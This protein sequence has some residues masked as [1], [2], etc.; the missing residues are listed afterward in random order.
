MYRLT[1]VI[2]LAVL[3]LGIS[4]DPGW[5]GQDYCVTCAGPDKIYLCTVDTGGAASAGLSQQLYC[6]RE[7]ARQGGHDSCSVKRKAQAGC[8]GEPHTLVYGGDNGSIGGPVIVTTP[9]IVTT[10]DARPEPDVRQTD[11]EAT[12]NPSAQP[13]DSSGQPGA[14]D[15]AAISTP[16]IAKPPPAAKGPPK[17]VVELAKRAAA[18]SKKQ[19]SNAG[20]AVKG[21]VKSAGKTVGKAA[22]KTW[23]CLTSF[24]TKC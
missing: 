11:A 2:M 15:P 8:N 18:S 5:T 9:K 13:A 4:K 6:I 24:F 3:L 1:A 21:G 10:P 14:G 20:Q 17:T 12:P 19:L 7:L 23:D 16:A 22:K